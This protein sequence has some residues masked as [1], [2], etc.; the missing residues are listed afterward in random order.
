[1]RFYT[2]ESLR[3]LGCNYENTLLYF[4][5]SGKMLIQYDKRNALFI[6]GWLQIS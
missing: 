1:M 3:L 5:E 2:G 6:H 4:V